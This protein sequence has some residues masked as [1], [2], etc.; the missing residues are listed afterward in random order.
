MTTY[1][2]VLG[3]DRTPHYG[4]KGQWPEPDRWLRVEGELVPCGRGLH[5]CER[6]DLVQ[7]LGPEIWECEVGEERVRDGDKTVCREARLVRR[8]ETWN[9]RTARLF[10]CD[11]AERVLPLWE[12][13]YPND[14][15][16]HEAVAVARRYAEGQATAEELAAAGDAARDAAWDAAR[17]AARA[18]ARAAAW[19]AACCQ[20]R[21]LDRCLGRCRGRCRG[22]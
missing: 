16:A 8:L 6:G 17:D 14:R 3:T 5:V 13:E 2:K 21:C 12:A 20:G 4:G 7:W 15:R 10:A 19:D 1:Y 11:C 9:E 22:R 18:A